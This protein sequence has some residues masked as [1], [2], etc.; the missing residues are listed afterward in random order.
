E[1]IARARGDGSTFAVLFIDLDGFKAINDTLGHDA[2]DELL[3]QIAARLR[4]AV[5]TGDVVARFAGD[6]V[7]V[8]LERV[9]RPQD[10][11]LVASS[12]AATLREP[13][14]L[15]AGRRDIA[16][17]IGIAV[18]APP[19]A[20]DERALLRDADAAMYEAKR[21]GRDAVLYAEHLGARARSQ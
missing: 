16:G 12:L 1:A 5:R 18:A 7:V 20:L 8:I 4:R 19:H 17:S 6:E 3:V 21:S 10:A 9:E 15:S 11:P 14:H 13:L 2:G